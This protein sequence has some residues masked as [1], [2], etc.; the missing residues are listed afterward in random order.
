MAKTEDKKQDTTSDYSLGRALIIGAVGGFL[1][2]LFLAIS[3]F[4]NLTEVAPKTLLLRPWIQTGWS[5]R[6]TGHIVSSIIATILSLLPA[7]IYFVLFRKINSI[8]MGIGYGILLWGVTFFLLQPL[9]PY[10]RPMM[11]LNLETWVT[12]VCISILYGLFT[13]YS[14]SYDYHEIKIRKIKQETES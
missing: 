11:E 7:I 1:W 6:L 12:T 5:D 10:T 9:L 13:G 2:S 3:Y 14:I 8:W 4:F